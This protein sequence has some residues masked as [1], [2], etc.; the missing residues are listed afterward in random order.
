LKT[1]HKF[2]V[3]RVKPFFGSYED[4]ISC[5][6]LDQNQYY[7]KYIKYYTCNPHIRKSMTFTIMWEDGEASIPWST[8]LANTQQYEEYI[9]SRPDLFPL[10]YPAAVA[11][12]RIA[13][14][15]KLSMSD[16]MPGDK[17][18][19]SLRLFDDTDRMWYDS[20]DLIKHT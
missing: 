17:L 1:E 14:I 16:I 18:Y 2:H 12:K 11:K 13:E 8:D 9:N 3:S 10:R 19:M 20:L 7:I 15:N 5:A 4:A 6:K